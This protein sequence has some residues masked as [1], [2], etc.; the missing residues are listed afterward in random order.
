MRAV[1][2]F[3]PALTPA[4]RRRFGLDSVWTRLA[5]LQPYRPVVLPDVGGKLSLN[6]GLLCSLQSAG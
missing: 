5:S 1:G 4:L 6:E 2:A 3:V